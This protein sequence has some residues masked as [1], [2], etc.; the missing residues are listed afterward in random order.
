LKGVDAAADASGSDGDGGD[1]AGERDVG[2]GGAEARFGSQGE[3]A[4]D[5][6]ESVE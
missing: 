2:V 3:M 5:G 4:V 6:A 1:S